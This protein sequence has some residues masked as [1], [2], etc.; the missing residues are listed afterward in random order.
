MLLTLTN[1]AIK[2]INIGDIRD[3][4]KLDINPNKR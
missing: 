2:L 4:Y 3:S 1:P